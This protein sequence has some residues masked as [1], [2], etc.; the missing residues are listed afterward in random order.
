MSIEKL[1]NNLKKEGKC[2][3]WYPQPRQAMALECPAFELLFGGAAGGGKTDFLLADYAAGIPQYGKDWRG[4]LFRK[5]YPELEEVILRAKELYLPIEAEYHEQKKT[6]TFPNR[7]FLRLRSLDHESDVEHY[8]GHQ[9]TWVG[10]DELGNYATDFQWVYMSSRARS[11]SGAKCYLRG[12]A[13]PGGVGHAWIKNRFING[14]EP[15]KIYKDAEGITHCFIPSKLEDNQILMRNDPDYEKRLNRLPEHLRRALREGDWDV[16]AGQYFDEW[17]RERH[18][19][20]PFAL[21]Q[22]SWYKFYAFDW[23]YNKPY[24]LIKL[25]VSGDGKVI[26]YGEIYGCVPGEVDKGVRESSLEAAR[27]AKA[28]ADLEGVTDIVMDPACWAKQDDNPSVA[29]N[30]QKVGFRCEKANNERVLGWGKLHELMKTDDEHGRPMFQAF[31]TCVHTIR[32]L[33]VL[34]PDP[35]NP[36]DV[37]SKLE[38]HLADAVRYGVTHRTIKYPMRRLAA[39]TAGF[40]H[41]PKRWDTLKDNGF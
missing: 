29:E 24:A 17:R 20:K 32:T 40:R 25:G 2:V 35:H 34:L 33:P 12:T 36:E 15:E 31:D 26:Q 41:T 18:V 13:N 10:F 8:Q 3:V 37:D 14:F 27:K 4:I 38:D 11:A 5:T 39:Q 6:F 22:G 23:G 21:T 7:A 16:I 9:Y 30:F 19:I 1:V 28:D